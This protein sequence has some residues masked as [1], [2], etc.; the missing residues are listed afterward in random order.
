MSV[1]SGMCCIP[2]ST[3]AA[4][5][6]TTCVWLDDEPE[7]YLTIGA[8]EKALQRIIIGVLRPSTLPTER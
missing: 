6:L 8:A 5:F 1:E 2:G 3:E 7:I 4:N